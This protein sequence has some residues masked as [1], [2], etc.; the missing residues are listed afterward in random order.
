MTLQASYVIEFEDE[1]V[2]IVVEEA[3]GLTFHAVHP[4]AFDLQGH[5]FADTLEASR[6]VASVMRV[7]D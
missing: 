4:R 6:A 7:G 3:E 5:Q 2:G 1:P